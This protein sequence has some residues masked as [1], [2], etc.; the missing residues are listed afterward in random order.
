M[1]Q[2]CGPRR[3]AQKVPSR[4]S[5]REPALPWQGL[6]VDSQSLS[7][8]AT[9]W[10]QVGLGR[11]GRKLAGQELNVSL[12]SKLREPKPGPVLSTP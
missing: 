3:D 9:P 4:E 5:I 11:S 12:L 10:T 2:V 7:R 6:E 1:L 8:E